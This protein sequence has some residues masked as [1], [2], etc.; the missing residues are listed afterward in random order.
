M[1]ISDWS[2]DVCS[3]DLLEQLGCQRLPTGAVLAFAGPVDGGRAVMTNAGW[4]T[5]V[6]E[7]RERFGF[8]QVRLLNDYAAFAL[9]LEH[10][11][12]EI[13]R[14]SCRERVCTYV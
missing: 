5:T 8:A 7:L 13:G 1:R 14:E 2:S 11:A 9:G 12:E 6:S 10:L 3:S 4:D